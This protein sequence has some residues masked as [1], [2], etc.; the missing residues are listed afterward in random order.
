M[1]LSICSDPDCPNKREVERLEAKIRQLE[2][3]LEQ[4]IHK[5]NYVN[6]RDTYLFKG[7]WDEPNNNKSNR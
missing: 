1:Y 4:C 3:E 5:I 6:T 2:N 7:K